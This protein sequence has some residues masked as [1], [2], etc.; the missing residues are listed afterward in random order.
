M[1]NSTLQLPPDLDAH[2]R[3]HLAEH[4]GG[5]LLAYV[6]KA[7]RRQLLRDTIHTIR[8]RN[9][10]ADPQVIEEEIQQALDDVRADHH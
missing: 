4:G 9:A 8:S 7:V 2:L 6:S 1:P 3:A 10:D 5:D